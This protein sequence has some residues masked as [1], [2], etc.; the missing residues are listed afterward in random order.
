[1]P[2]SAVRQCSPVTIDDEPQPNTPQVNM[3][4]A[5]Q[6]LGQIEAIERTLL[7]LSDS[8]VNDARL[9]TLGFVRAASLPLEVE[10]PVDAKDLFFKPYPDDQAKQM[11][12]GILNESGEGE[13]DYLDYCP[14]EH[15]STSACAHHLYMQIWQLL[16]WAKYPRFVSWSATERYVFNLPSL[17]AF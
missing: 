1:M 12:M 6:A 13:D 14:R 9:S 3:Q 7:A 17:T 5:Q 16:S 10:R 4:R 8:V 11:C 2:T 15:H